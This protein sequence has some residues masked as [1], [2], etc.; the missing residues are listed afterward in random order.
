VARRRGQWWEVIGVKIGR[1][2][3]G[4]GARGQVVL[5]EEVNEGAS[6]ELNKADSNRVQN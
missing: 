6:W 3:R 5:G 4:S 2:V 1:G